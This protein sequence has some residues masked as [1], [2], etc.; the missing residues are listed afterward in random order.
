MKKWLTY[1]GLFLVVYLGF[2]VVNIPA[3]WVL[4][5]VES[6]EGVE[7]KSTQGSIW[8]AH[9]DAI[10]LPENVI[11]YNVEID[12]NILSL[13]T[14]NPSANITFGGSQL[15][16]PQG[17]LIV[18]NLFS[19]LK[20][21]KVNLTVDA[22][23]VL[24]QVDLPIAL[25]AHDK[26]QVNLSEYELGQPVCNV[27]SG[28]VNWKNASVTAFE[29]T[30]NLGPLKA[31]ISCDKGLLYVNV[32]PKNHLGLTYEIAVR[33]DG[34][35]SGHGYLKPSDN[36][37]EQLKMALPFLNSPDSKGRYRLRF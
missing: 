9:F 12:V 20:L 26:V 4:E 13:F 32:D 33:K 7:I 21:Q 30:I 14:F 6:P 34:K 1:G 27:A 22:N 31:E 17:S 37:P 35:A 10:Q 5:Q 29:E 2:L 19:T 25:T 36:F 16:G 24:S 28:Q 11:L 8:H 23:E 15:P 18:S 3:V